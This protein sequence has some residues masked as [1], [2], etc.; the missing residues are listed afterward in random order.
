MFSEVFAHLHPIMVH[1][2]IV[3]ITV[4]LLYDVATAFWKHSID[5]K[6]GLWLWMI[7]AVG[8]WLSIATGPEDDARGNTSFLDIHSTLADITVWIA[9]ALVVFRLWML[10][11]NNRSIV[12]GILIGY[13][14]LSIASCA[15]VLA[16]GYYGGKMVYNDGVGVKVNGTVVNPPVSG[17]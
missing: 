7:A 15:L 4:A 16:T 6:K 9:T 14:L 8:G 17:K 11:K 1:F 5:P 12:K 13:L 2:P 10:W 3:M